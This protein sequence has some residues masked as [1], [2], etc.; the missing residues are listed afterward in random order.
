VADTAP[1]GHGGSLLSLASVAKNYGTGGV[2]ISDVS[3]AGVLEPWL[4]K[5]DAQNQQELPI[6]LAVLTAPR[7]P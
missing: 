5:F 6:F 4:P 2:A 1:Y 7:A 3:V